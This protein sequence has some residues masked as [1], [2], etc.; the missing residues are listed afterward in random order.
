MIRHTVVK[1]YASPH[2]IWEFGLWLPLDPIPLYIRY[3]LGLF[4]SYIF[5]R[6]HW[7]QGFRNRDG[8]RLLKIMAGHHV[9]F[10][11]IVFP[12]VSAVSG[13]YISEHVLS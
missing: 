11:F 6:E 1:S 2:R 7:V 4:R 8:S 10:G 3:W 9:S 12:N 13:I 5:C